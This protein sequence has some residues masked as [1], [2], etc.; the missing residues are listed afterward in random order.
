M[1]EILAFS[2][3]KTTKIYGLFELSGAIKTTKI[4]GLF[5]LSDKQSPRLE[6]LLSTHRNLTDINRKPK[7][8]CKIHAYKTNKTA[9]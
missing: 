9:K 2:A 4:Y 7:K 3:I 6:G 1:T 8:L 5:E